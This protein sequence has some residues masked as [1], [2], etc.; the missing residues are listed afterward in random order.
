MSRIYHYTTL[1]NLELILSNSTIRL[2]SLDQMDDLLEGASVDLSPYFFIS[3]WSDNQEE[4]I[5][6]WY[7]YT[8]KMRG[9]RIEADENF[10]Q[11]EEDYKSGRIL[12]IS[13]SNVIAFK[14][15]A[16][17]KDA[18]L[19]K[20]NYT[21]TLTSCLETARG[22]INEN[23]FEIG[24]TKPIAWAFQHEVRFR[25]Y[26]MHKKHLVS[27]GDT[28]NQKVWNSMFAS[29]G[30]PI[31]YIDIKFDRLKF[32]NANFILGPASTNEDIKELQ[33]IISQY[34]PNYCGNIQ[35]S[36]LQI[37]FKEKG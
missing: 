16:G 8:D 23:V 14:L 30:T 27:Y 35:R 11:L 2:T 20:V 6:L 10:L 24:R 5:P 26:G 12:N 37:K 17:A 7:M 13:D 29:R 25:V 33:T 32:N 21:D 28:L 15:V 1:N 9:V 4:N 18:F 22:F 34:L 36:N 19:C 3:S 31:K